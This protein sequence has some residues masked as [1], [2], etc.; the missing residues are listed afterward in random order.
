MAFGFDD[1]PADFIKKLN[2][3]S[4]KTDLDRESCNETIGFLANRIYQAGGHRFRQRCTCKAS[5][6]LIYKYRCSQ[7]IDRAE[8]T[9]SVGH[10]DVTRMERHHCNSLLYSKVSLEAR[11]LELTLNQ[12]SHPAYISKAIS[13]EAL[14]FIRDR[15]ATSTPGPIYHKLLASGIPG[16]HEI[17]QHQVR[18]RWIQYSTEKWTRDPE[19]LA[20]AMER[21]QEQ[22]DTEYHAPVSVDLPSTLRNVGGRDTEQAQDESR[23]TASS[24]PQSDAFSCETA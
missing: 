7:D 13:P 3:K 19:A 11:F 22:D 10:R 24:G 23:D 20:S 21:L 12:D 6:G 2:Q 18:Y 17:A 15:V 4:N 5:T 1:L 9:T 14:A 16:A 8:K